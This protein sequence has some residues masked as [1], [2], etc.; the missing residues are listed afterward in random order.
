[1]MEVLLILTSWE[2]FRRGH[3]QHGRQ[4][5]SGPRRRSDNSV[6]MGFSIMM[7]SSP[8]LVGAGGTLLGIADTMARACEK[9]GTRVLG[10]GINVAVFFAISHHFNFPNQYPRADAMKN[11]R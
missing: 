10:S 1:M 8:L 3:I 2:K 6:A 4:R 5:I 11:S 9:Y 7:V